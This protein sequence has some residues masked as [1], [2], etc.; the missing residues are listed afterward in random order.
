ML[1][2]QV[3]DC[4]SNLH[5]VAAGCFSGAFVALASEVSGSK[6][7]QERDDRDSDHDFHQ[8]EAP[9]EMCSSTQ[10]RL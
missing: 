7:G 9:L 8:G 6:Y 2:L 3:N 1:E 4:T 10:K 5:Q